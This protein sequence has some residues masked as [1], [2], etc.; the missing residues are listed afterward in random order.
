[1]AIAIFPILAIIGGVGFL[2]H[3]K[4]APVLPKRARFAVKLVLG[5]ITV[6]MGGFVVA[7][8]A[9][10]VK[11]KSF[12]GGLGTMI[13]T[14]EY[15][16]KRL[17]GGHVV[18]EEY[19]GNYAGYGAYEGQKITVGK[20]S[21]TGAVNIS[22]VRTVDDGSVVSEG[23]ENKW[24]YIYRDKTKIGLI[25]FEGPDD[26]PFIVID[27]GKEASVSAYVMRKELGDIQVDIGGYDETYTWSGEND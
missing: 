11:E 23:R 8:V 3:K 16:Q 2:A 26:K 15:Q 25:W 13:G 22:G 10:S 19:R 9:F 20:N 21:I 24:A 18:S 6:I 5:A 1:M 17:S 12:G 27:L 7:T 14:I 4:F